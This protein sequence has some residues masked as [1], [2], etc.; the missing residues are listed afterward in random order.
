MLY[1]SARS[2]KKAPIPQASPTSTA[3]GNASP[4]VSEKI[5]GIQV[6]SATFSRM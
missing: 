3:S 4:G 5:T 2:R 1:Q 6:P